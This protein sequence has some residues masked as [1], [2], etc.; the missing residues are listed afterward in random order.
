MAE[1]GDSSTRGTTGPRGKKPAPKKGGI[2]FESFIVAFSATTSKKPQ[3]SPAAPALGD[4]GA[5]P[6][7]FPLEAEVVVDAGEITLPDEAKVEPAPPLPAQPEPVEVPPITYAEPDY[8]TMGWESFEA[9]PREFFELEIPIEEKPEYV[10]SPADQLYSQP[11]EP[12]ADLEGMD[13]GTM[14]LPG[15][16]EV[17]PY[18]LFKARPAPETPV[19]ADSPLRPQRKVI[20]PPQRAEEIPPVSEEPMPPPSAPKAIIEVVAPGLAEPPADL[21]AAI[22][23]MPKPEGEEAVLY[24]RRKEAIVAPPLKSVELPAIVGDFSLGSL[25][26]EMINRRASDL[27]ITVGSVPLIRIHGDLYRTEY[28]PIT[29]E[30]AQELLYPLLND[31]QRYS[32]EDSGDLDFAIE[33]QGMARFRVNCFM[34]NRGLGAAFRLIPNQV[35]RLEDLGL[36]RAVRRIARMKK[37]LVIVTGPTGSGKTTTLAAIVN[38]INLNRQAHI[39]T[40]EDP[41]EF[42]HNSQRCLITQREVGTHSNNF[43]EALKAAIRED[44]DIIMVGEMRDLDTINQ[45]I[46]AAETGLLVLGTLH[47]NSAS[48]TIDRIIDVFPTDEQEQIRTMLSDSLKAVLAQQLL[49]TRDGRGR[50]VAMEILIAT[51][52]LAN[53]IREGKSYQIETMIQTGK[54]QGMQGMDL[55]LI[56]LIKAGLIDPEQIRER[57]IDFRAFERAGITFNH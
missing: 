29:Q 10:P 13:T 33:I 49:K 34:Q 40:I 22:S 41:L 20:P 37:G 2:D 53:V 52:G 25:F 56:R 54:E 28:P 39:I 46:R 26:K 18:S 24:A 32:F 1:Q 3:K 6:F 44:P 15:G 21:M 55:A 4:L 17:K 14:V 38:E 45:A 57:V 12:V 47:T 43:A 9:P 42:I 30:L 50:V 36:P 31:N 7:S 16:R 8:S 51:P 23:G 48:K 35:P 11:D 27:H 19:V 5:M